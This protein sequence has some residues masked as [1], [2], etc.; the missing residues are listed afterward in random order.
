MLL[1]CS[2]DCSYCFNF[3]ASWHPQLSVLES[4]W[5]VGG[6]YLSDVEIDYDTA[7]TSSSKIVISGESQSL[8][9]ALT[10]P[11][12]ELMVSVF[13]VWGLWN[14]IYDDGVG[15]WIDLRRT[16]LTD[17]AFGFALPSP[18]PQYKLRPP[19]AP[20]GSTKSPVS[21]SFVFGIYFVAASLFCGA[22]LWYNGGNKYIRLQGMDE[23][24]AECISQ[25]VNVFEVSINYFPSR[26]L[27]TLVHCMQTAAHF[28]WT[29][30]LF[31]PHNSKRMTP[32]GVPHYTVLP[33]QIILPCLIG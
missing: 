13:S 4:T 14:D 33:Q 6:D 30:C 19:R 5:D 32:L 25:W 29:A 24:S 20:L 11:D 12:S 23:S 3:F 16:G 1:F 18:I 8:L 7:R 15:G 26:E 28:V 22:G 9:P 31:L 10:V 2:T 17:E 27:W 21:G